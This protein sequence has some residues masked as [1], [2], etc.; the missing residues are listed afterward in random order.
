M[1]REFDLGVYATFVTGKILATSEELSDFMHYML[2]DD[3]DTSNEKLL[4]ET[5][6]ISIIVAHKELESIHLDRSIES[7]EEAYEYLNTLLRMGYKRSYS[8][9]SLV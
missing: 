8:I 9:Q 5:I 3:A 7:Q 6:K 2:G 4:F 1:K